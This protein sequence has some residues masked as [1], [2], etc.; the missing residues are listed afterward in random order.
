MAHRSPAQPLRRT[1]IRTRLKAPRQP[2][3]LWIVC[4]LVSLALHA[5]LLYV[6]APWW[7]ARPLWDQ[8]SYG[9]E[10]A[11]TPNQQ[12]PTVAFQTPIPQ[13]DLE[14]LIE[15]VNLPTIEA[16]AGTSPE[17]A[18]IETTATIPDAPR[19][20]APWAGHESMPEMTRPIAD[21]LGPAAESLLTPT[22]LPIGGGYEGRTADA[23]GKL[24]SERGGTPR[25]EAAVNAGLAW[26]VAH[27]HADGGWRFSHHGGPCDGQCRNSGSESST[28]AATGLALL[29]LLGAGHTPLAGQHQAAVSRGLDYLRGRMIA[30]PRGGDFQEGTMYGQGLT[31]IVL[32]EAFALS[33]DET[34]KQPAQQAIDYIV[35]T[36]HFRG[37][38]RYFP[39]QPGDT[40]VLGWQWMALKSGQ[41]AGLNVP[42]KTLDRAGEFLGSVQ[43]DDGAA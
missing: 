40:T 11:S 35:S 32:C 43:S 36:Q 26:L 10:V 16:P 29:P 39:G 6:L 14:A 13:P 24:A 8:D 37:G 22:E 1:P 23:R 19:I 20:A 34:L 21:T 28:T 15:L 12:P 5:V 18:A 27:Q 31:T 33:H 9:P 17:P 3:I 4:T 38:W 2:L 42:R 7:M 25:S 30:S 41:M